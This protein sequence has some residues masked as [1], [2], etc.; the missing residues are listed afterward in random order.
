M[1]FVRTHLDEKLQGNLATALKDIDSSYKSKFIEGLSSLDIDFSRSINKAVLV[2]SARDKRLKSP[3]YAVIGVYSKLDGTKGVVAYQPT[4]GPIVDKKSE[5]V[6]NKSGEEVTVRSFGALSWTKWLGLMTDV[7]VIDTN[8]STSLKS[9]LKSKE[10]KRASRIASQKA[11]KQASRL[12]ASSVTKGQ[13][14]IKSQSKS[15][16]V[17]EV[18]DA[19]RKA[20]F[21]KV[22]DSAK[23][24]DYKVS[25]RT[26]DRIVLSSTV[27]GW[28]LP[29]ILIDYRPKSPTRPLVRAGVISDEILM[30][31]LDHN[32][33]TTIM[34]YFERVAKLLTR[35]S[36]TT[37]LYKIFEV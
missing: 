31:E 3:Q 5:T 18:S 33:L 13:A 22:E 19:E 4:V 27:K 24:Y 35:I 21:S 1:T 23:K 30:R 12:G 32:D 34:I 9:T 36:K 37:D 15:V 10:D 20:I 17:P 7:Y 26:K 11:S 6:V 16:E 8:E 14:P 25:R 29:D 28:G 2:K